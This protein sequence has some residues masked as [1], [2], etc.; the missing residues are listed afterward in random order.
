MTH[1][2][3]IDDSS[4]FEGGGLG[5]TTCH[6][7]ISVPLMF[8]S[9]LPHLN[10]A[11]V[12]IHIP[13]THPNHLKVFEQL[14]TAGDGRLTLQ[15]LQDG[16]NHPEVQA[17]LSSYEYK[18]DAASLMAHL[19]PDNN[20]CTVLEFLKGMV[21]LAQGDTNSHHRSSVKFTRRSLHSS[22]VKPTSTVSW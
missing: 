21:K 1:R 14:D 7:T 10:Y 2:R 13:M 20:G 17:V 9:K 12:R 3:D 18:H 5:S 16:W 6:T 11:D 15:M 19:D 8:G 4:T 22:P